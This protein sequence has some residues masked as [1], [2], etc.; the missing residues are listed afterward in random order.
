VR[1]VF[2]DEDVEPRIELAL[3]GFDVQS[4]AKLKMQGIKNGALLRWLASNGFE[5]LVAKDKNIPFQNPL[6]KAGIGFVNIQGVGSLANRFIASPSELQNAVKTVK[7]GEVIVV[8][9]PSLE[10]G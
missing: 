10:P 5:V 6:H 8:Q 9:A 7:A 2:L 4:I 3:A 1:R